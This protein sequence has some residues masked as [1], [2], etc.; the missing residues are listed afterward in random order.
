[1]KKIFALWEW[2]RL[3]TK[4]KKFH[5]GKRK[6]IKRYKKRLSEEAII[7]LNNSFD[8]LK[9]GLKLKM[10]QK[11][12]F[13]V[14]FQNTKD[15]LKK[16]L[17]D[18]V[19]RPIREFIE[20]LIS[21]FIIVFI[22]RALIV[23]T[24]HI[25]TGSMIPTIMPGDRI[26]ASKFIYGFSIPFT[27]IKFAY[28]NKPSKGDI[29]IFE[30]PS[31]VKEEFP[32]APG[33]LDNFVKRVFAFGG[34]SIEIKDQQIYVNGE[35]VKRELVKEHFIFKDQHNS[36]W[37][38]YHAKL[39]KEQF[40]DNTYYTVN[41]IPNVYDRAN[42]GVDKAGKISFDK[43]TIVGPYIV[44]KDHFFVIGD[45]RD[46]SNDSRYWGPVPMD[47]IKGA[48][49]ITWLSIIDDEIAFKRILNIFYNK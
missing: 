35:A 2:Y 3:K 18:T 38:N 7:E 27:N 41:K 14:I 1:M 22:L 9:K 45:N 39:Y 17:P 48:P 21:A 16:H 6:Y 26:F 28:W 30:P 20:I 46:G 31:N 4:G 23:D 37:F 29:I 49:M 42:F 12:E 24:Y 43:E 19:S 36:E 25:P 33:T 15:V 40:G 8:E 32:G 44:P 10:A 13:E 11:E 47:N 34:D 5:N